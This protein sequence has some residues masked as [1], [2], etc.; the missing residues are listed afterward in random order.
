VTLPLAILAATVPTALYTLL[1]WWLDR[2]EK[3]PL[4]LLVAAFLWGALPAVALA[5][6]FGRVVQIPLS[7]SPLGPGI[8]IGP[9]AAIVEEPAKALALLLIYWFA[10]NEIDGP[11]DGIVY[12]AL[13]GFGFAMSENLLFYLAHPAELGS[14]FWLRSVLFGLSHAL[15]TSIVGLALGYARLHPE[16]SAWP[17]FGGAL[18]LAIL[19]HGLHNLAVV[20]QAIGVSLAWL[21]QFAGVITVLAVAGLAWRHEAHWL[22]H[23]LGQ[24]IALGIISPADYITVIAAPR[25]ART[26][27]RTLLSSGWAAYRQ[28]RQ[29]HHLITRLAF[30]NDRLRRGDPTVTVAQRDQLRQQI[31][32]LRTGRAGL[33]A[34]D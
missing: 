12:G 10:R 20:Q 25:R 16:R 11:L 30:M 26:E 13:I 14:L 5:L 28:L 1:I 34:E 18:L 17:L 2:Y 4:P 7:A 29:R 27:L 21:L 24:E 6:F 33:S 32:A 8:G 9:V 19:L 22:R 15:F 3:E 31:L 23:E